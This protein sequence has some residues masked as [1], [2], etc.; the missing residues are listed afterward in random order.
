[1]LSVTNLAG[2]TEALTSL[3]GFKMQE[4][5]Y[6]KLEV[7]FTSL[8][9]FDRWSNPGYSLIEEEAVI[10]VEGRTFRVK[11]LKELR[12]RKEVTALSTFYDLKGKRQ[13]TIF[14]GTRTFN[15]F[16]TFIF[17][18]TGWTFVSLDV[19][20]SKLIENFGED[21]VIQLNEVLC[22]V[23]ECEF[24]ILPGNVVSFAKQTG[25]DYDGQY[26]YGHNVK[27]LSKNV[28][29]SNLRTA[30]KGY[31][32][33]GLEVTYRSPNVGKYGEHFADPVRDDKFATSESMLEHLKQTLIDY[34]EATFEM[35]TLELTSRELGERVWLIYEPMGLEFQ[36]RILSKT[37]GMRNDELYV[38]SVVVGNKIP[39]KISDILIEQSVEIN[40]NAKEFRSKFHQTNEL[41][42]ASVEEVNQSIAQLNIKA[43]NM[44]LSV[45]DLVG[46]VDAVTGRV[47]QSEASI[48]IH[49][50]LISSKVSEVD[51]NGNRVV[52]MINQTAHGVTIEASKINLVGF[53]TISSLN[54]PGAVTINEG[55]IVGS[56][57]TVGRG[58]GNPQLTMTAI[59]GSHIIKSSDGAGFRVHSTGTLSLQADNDTIY[60]NSKFWARARLEVSG[61]AQFNGNIDALYSRITSKE[62]Y[63]NNGQPLID[64]LYLAN[65]NY[66]SYSAMTNYIAGLNLTTVAWVNNAISSDHRL[67]ENELV[68]WAN[69]KFALK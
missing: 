56:S 3:Q 8:P 60:A 15:E 53:V 13:D 47:T 32:A 25:G 61:T 4:D 43:D 41:I 48:S 67:Q 55:N 63:H 17:Q 34:P 35:D 50:G 16:A 18:G 27:A 51:F 62:F 42:H 24:H 49:S 20:G 57:F 66:L 31:G 2:Q 46:K 44:T 19:T 58:T 65:M 52:S 23:F 64:A 7:T 45:S 28:V 26:R 68:A 37:S 1:M 9:V 12:N 11:Q 54:T 39:R 40:E 10:D 69:G 6:G 33:E 22:T 59:Q 36:T 21:N 5:I 38:Q 30:I 29:T 14:G